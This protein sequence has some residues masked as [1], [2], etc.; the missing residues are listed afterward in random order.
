[1]LL[2]MNGFSEGVE[3]LIPVYLFISSQAMKIV[4]FNKKKKEKMRWYNTS[5]KDT[6]KCYSPIINYSSYDQ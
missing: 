5:L 6:S 4:S 3:E 2:S 1:M